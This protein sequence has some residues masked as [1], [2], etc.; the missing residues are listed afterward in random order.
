MPKIDLP[1]DSLG[2]KPTKKQLETLTLLAK[3]GV[4]VHEWSGVRIDWHANVRDGDKF[5]KFNLNTLHKFVDWGWVEKTGDD[6]WKS[7]DW[8]L[9]DRGRMVIDKGET[10]K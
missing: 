6:D 3:D 2:P 8:K 5:E 9:S 10:R 7:R 4:T 1:P